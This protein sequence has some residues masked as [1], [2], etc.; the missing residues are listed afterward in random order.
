MF[1]CQ[2]AP[3]DGGICSEGSLQHILK[4]TGARYVLCLPKFQDMIKRHTDETVVVVPLGTDVDAFCS[5]ER[6]SVVVAPDDGAYA[7]Y[8]SGKHDY[9]MP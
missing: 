7:I 4:D 8:T 5:R 3:I 9:A 2:Y 6:P 1:R